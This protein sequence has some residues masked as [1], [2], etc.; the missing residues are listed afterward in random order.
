MNRYRVG[1]GFNTDRAEAKDLSCSGRLQTI[2]PAS[3]QGIGSGL[4]GG[5]F[6]RRPTLPHS[7]PC[8]TIGAE[9][10]NFR[11][12]DG[13]GCCLFAI[14]TEKS[15]RNLECRI[16]SRYLCQLFCG[17]AARLISTSKLHTL[18]CL[19]TWPINLVVFEESLVK[20]VSMLKGYLI[21]RWASRLDAFSG[22]PFRT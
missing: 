5:D 13:N 12:R 16:G 14:A 22:Y 20:H 21:L 10:L 2:Q 8:S 9:E 4:D 7:F 1:T 19:H 6:R 11:V 18:L 15:V 17:Q 3:G